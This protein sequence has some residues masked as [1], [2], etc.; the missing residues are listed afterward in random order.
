M[1]DFEVY[2][3]RV[4]NDRGIIGVGTNDFLAADIRAI[5]RA[6]KEI[7]PELRTQ[8]MRDAK[9]IGAEAA[10]L[11]K[12]ALP[13]TAPLSGMN[14]RGNYGWNNQMT[15]KGRVPATKVAVSFKT[16]QGKNAKM[17]GIETTSLVSVRV[18]APMTAISDIAG[19]SG[20]WVGKGN[21]GSGYSKP[22][23]DRYGNIRVHKLNGQGEAMIRGLG[24]RGS[25]YAWPTIESRKPALEAQVREVVEKYAAI[26]NGKFK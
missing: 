12:P 17:M 18:P 6:L 19:R 2:V 20:S 5:N 7:N 25:R 21:K 23:T 16:S 10:S 8:F 22:Y 26:A 14:T 3:P 1:A 9:A 4:R 15:K 24:G 11:V 13:T